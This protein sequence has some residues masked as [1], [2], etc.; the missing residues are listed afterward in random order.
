[1]KVAASNPTQPNPTQPQGRFLSEEGLVVQS[2][3]RFWGLESWYL[4]QTNPLILDSPSNLFD[5]KS[6]NFFKEF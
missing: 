1:M 2:N 3:P 4:V 6:L 5:S